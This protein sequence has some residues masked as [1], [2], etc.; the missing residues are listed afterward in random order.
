[1]AIRIMNY[2]GN[3]ALTIV[4]SF[5]E[6]IIESLVDIDASF[7]VDVRNGTP[8][9]KRIRSDED[10]SNLIGNMLDFDEISSICMDEENH[11]IIINLRKFGEAPIDVGEIFELPEE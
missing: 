4:P 2:G 3:S 1:M 6:C 10:V 11:D 5:D 9:Y 7:V 8:V